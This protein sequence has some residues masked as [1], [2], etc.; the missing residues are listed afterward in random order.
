MEV[1][2]VT[3]KDNQTFVVAVNHG[4]PGPR[5]IQGEKGDTGATGPVGP[6]GP[7]GERGPQGIQG[8]TG[9]TG[10]QGQTG[11]TGAQGPTG[12]PGIYYGTQTPTD[13][14]ISFW[15]DPS[16]SASNDF[17]ETVN[18]VTAISSS[19]T[20]TQYPSALAVYNYIQSLSIQG[21]QF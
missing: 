11:A 21:V 20:N 6:A 5:G 4:V 16:G 14:D 3:G 8:E 18:K 7:Q 17:E 1:V 10:P 12:D 2:E 9:A 15:I 13:P 19:S